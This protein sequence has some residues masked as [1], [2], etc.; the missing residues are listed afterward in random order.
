[1]TRT[2]GPT[3]DHQAQF[4]RYRARWRALRDSCAA[5]DRFVAEEGVHM[6]YLSAGLR[7]P[8]RIVWCAGPLEMARSRTLIAQ[9][10]SPGGPVLCLLRDATQR[11]VSAAVMRSLRAGGQLRSVPTNQ[12]IEPSRLGRIITAAFGQ[13]VR[14]GQARPPRSWRTTLGLLRRGWR[15]RPL[16]SL[17]DSVAN[18]HD[19]A[20]FGHYQFIAE[21]W[22]LAAE[23]AP[24]RGLLQVAAEVGWLLPHEDVCWL[25]ERHASLKTDASGR[26]HNATGPAVAYHDGWRMYAWKGVLVPSWLIEKPERITLD[27]I[28]ATVDPQVR[29]C[30]IDIMT[31]A[32]FIAEGGA[33]SVAHDEAG[34]LW[35]KHWW[36]RL[37]AWA[38]VEVI[39]G[40]PEPDGSRKHYFLQ[41]PPDVRTPTEAVAWTY[42]MSETH[43]RRLQ[44]RT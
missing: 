4:A 6:A 20:Q 27:H 29:R 18:Q 14:E 7:P 8:R 23:V 9:S 12:L 40:T 1:M 32:R 35:R 3:P 28:D 39:N 2:I 42:G 13:A 17:T 15:R 22:G 5:A 11:Q 10:E 34:V 30:M 43:Y 25:A 41:V 38:A 37:D 16:A 26:L 24:L 21:V 19:L 33:L 31:P 36:P 44:L